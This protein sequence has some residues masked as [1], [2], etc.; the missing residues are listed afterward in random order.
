MG[1]QKPHENLHWWSRGFEIGLDR[2]NVDPIYKLM[3]S[4]AEEYGCQLIITSRFSKGRANPIRLRTP[5]VRDY[6]TANPR[7]HLRGLIKNSFANSKQ[8]IVYKSPPFS[9]NFSSKSSKKS[10][11]KKGSFKWNP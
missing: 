8:K 3:E 6:Y 5:K 2:P 10:A 11:F 4:V 7:N 9:G 1:I